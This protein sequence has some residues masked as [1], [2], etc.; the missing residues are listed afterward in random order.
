MGCRCGGGLLQGNQTKQA[1]SVEDLREKIFSGSRSAFNPIPANLK[2]Q[3][4]VRT[5]VIL[6]AA[7]K[8]KEVLFQTSS[9]NIDPSN[10]KVSKK[11]IIVFGTLD[12]AEFKYLKNI[13]T[14]IILTKIEYKNSFDLIEADKKY[15]I[16]SQGVTTFPCTYLIDPKRIFQRHIALFDVQKALNEFLAFKA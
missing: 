16:N 7:P 2:P 8:P 6:D 13:F 3:T 10:F 4:S 11:T 14:K 1:L 9:Y 15:L 5:P 12:N